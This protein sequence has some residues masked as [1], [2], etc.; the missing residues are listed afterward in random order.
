MDEQIIASGAIDTGFTRE[1]GWL[2][3]SDRPGL[4]VNVD[5]DSIPEVDLVGRAIHDIPLRA[6]GSVAYA[7]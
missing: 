3:L 5:W 7:V 2:T 6:D 4:G 1:G